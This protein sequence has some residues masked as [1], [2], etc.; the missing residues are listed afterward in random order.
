MGEDGFGDAWFGHGGGD[1]V[2]VRVKPFHMDILVRRG[3]DGESSVERK[4][5]LG[6]GEGVSNL[7]SELRR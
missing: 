5:A 1:V 6:V 4:Q 2:V 7:G 3:R